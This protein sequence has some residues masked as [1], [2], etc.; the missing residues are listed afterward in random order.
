MASK[1]VGRPTGR[2]SHNILLYQI[3]RPKFK[4]SVQLPPGSVQF[5]ADP[6]PCFCPSGMKRMGGLN[7][8]QSESQSVSSLSQES[9]SE[10]E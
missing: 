4:L 9:Q 7:F 8:Y 3:R 2:C 5:R 6:R 10:D 1:G